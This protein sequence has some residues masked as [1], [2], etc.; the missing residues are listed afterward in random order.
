M[1]IRERIIELQELTNDYFKTAELLNISYEEV[2]NTCED[3][4]EY[5][6]SMGVEE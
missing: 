5:A 6:N 1:N 3:Y 4:E 2:R